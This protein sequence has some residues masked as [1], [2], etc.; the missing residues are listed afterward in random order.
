VSSTSEFYIFRDSRR[1]T[2]AAEL[3]NELRTKLFDLRSLE[4]PD[5]LLFLLLQAGELECGLCDIQEAALDWQ[6]ASRLTDLLAQ[7]AVAFEGSTCDKRRLASA[8]LPILD[9]IRYSGQV[10]VSVP[11]GFAYY[12]LH[13]LDYADLI[14]R[15]NLNTRSA[16]VVGVRS[17]GTT[18]SAVVAAKLRTAGVAAQRFTVRPTGHP[19]DRQCEFDSR[20]RHAIAIALAANAEFLICDEGPGRSG[21]SLLSVAEALEREGVSLSRITILCSHNPDVA[22]LCAPD[23]VRRWGRYRV[24]AS[25]MTRRLPAEATD[26]LGS[27]EWRRKLIPESEPWPAVWPQME[28]LRYGSCD[29]RILLTFEGHGSYGAAVRARNEALARAGFGPSYVGQQAGFGRQ[30]M[31]KGRTAGPADITPQLLSHMAEYCSWR[32]AEFAVSDADASDLE[33]LTRVNFEREFGFAPECLLLP[34]ERPTICDSRMTP[35]EWLLT[36]AGRWLKL[37]AAIHGD[38]HFFPGPCDIAWDLAGIVVEWN[39]STAAREFLLEKY[40]EASG[41]DGARR[42]RDY[43]LA[44]ATFRMAWSSMAASSVGMGEE[45]DRLCRDYQRYRRWLQT[46]QKACVRH[47]AFTEV[48]TRAMLSTQS[49]SQV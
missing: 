13:P 4:L 6:P 49:G 19:Y 5:E 16:L 38:D 47:D 44:Y 30:I 10:S 43:E 27:G 23:V 31:A 40:K 33:T 46:H 35:H 18:L 9:Q 22:S 12:A 34:V 39:L 7:A 11:E 45:A 28:R 14:D 8:A 41:D 42:V 26:Y 36:D 24:A 20:Q 21:S 1:R 29:G 15:L 48:D 37:D 25:G 17:I 3:W 32:A 2:S